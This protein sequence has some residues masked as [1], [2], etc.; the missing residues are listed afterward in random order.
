MIYRL[1]DF[2]DRWHGEQK[3]AFLDM[4][5]LHTLC[6]ALEMAVLGNL[7]NGTKNLA[8][9]IAPRHYKTTF[10]SK[11]F[12]AWCF[13]EFAAD[14]EFILTSYSSD[15]STE[16]AMAIRSIICSDWYRKLY[17]E[18]VISKLE[19][20][21]QNYFKTTKG[22]HVYSVGTGGTVT[23]FGAGKTRRGFA[24]AII[25]DDPLKAQDAR[26]EAMRKSLQSFYTGTI[27]SRRNDV[28]KTPIILIAQR[29]HPDDLLG[30]CLNN[31]PKDWHV[32]SFPAIVDGEL[33]NPVTMSLD[34]LET[35][36]EVD[37]VTYW[38]QYMQTP[39]TPGGNIIKTSWWATYEPSELP[40]RG[41]MFLTADTAFKSKSDNDRSVIRAWL[42]NKDGLYEIDA[43]YGRWEFP[44]LLEEAKAFWVKMYK[45]GARDFYIED[46]A[47]GTPLEQVLRDSGIPATAWAPADYGYPDDKVGRMNAAAWLI[48]GGKVR[49]PRG[50]VAVNRPEMTPLYTTEECADMIEEAAAFARDMSHVHDDHCD[51]LTMATAIYSDGA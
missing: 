26:S 35:L 31:E 2:V 38:A 15:L 37:P 40:T 11:A 30:W 8:I 19:R 14:C 16:N 34:E 41:Y 27:K 21:V 22:G 43:V 4:P 3:T 32:V 6:D 51:T 10:A 36:K 7:P 49:V 33:L 12:P 29:L 9:T 25:I 18:V 28:N 24:G 46:K 1:F 45:Q 13:G 48:H 17:P 50:P 42:G 39:I 5:Y 20:N 23:G 44:Q 47:S